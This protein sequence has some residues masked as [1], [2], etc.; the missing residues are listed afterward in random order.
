MVLAGFLAIH[1]AK[2]LTSGVA[3][4]Y[5]HST[6]IWILVMTLASLVFAAEWR[7]LKRRGVDVE[8][9]FATLPPQ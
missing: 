7:S 3:G 8:R 5:F 6:F 4:W 2:D 9:R 1:V